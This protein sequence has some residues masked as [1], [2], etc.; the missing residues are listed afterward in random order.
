MDDIILNLLAKERVCVFSVVLADGTP[1]AAVVHYSH[2]TDPVRLFIQTYPTIKT[3]AIKENGG[4][5]KA[6]IVVGM[7]EEDFVT[8]QMRGDVRIVTDAEEL[9]SV[10]RTHYTKHP[11]AETYKDASTIFLEFT[12]AWWRYSDFKTEPET[13][14]EKQK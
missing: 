3:N 6:A 7:S 11:K 9:E 13:V 2:A 1:H 8:L 4:K 12:P 5:V 10:Y 14:I